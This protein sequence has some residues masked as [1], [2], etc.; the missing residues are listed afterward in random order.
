M[1]RRRY[2]RRRLRHKV[3]RFR[4]QRRRTSRRS[5]FFR[6]RRPRLFKARNIFPES[7]VVRIPFEGHFQINSGTA[8]N[9]ITGGWFVANTLS[10]SPAPNGPPAIQTGTASLSSAFQGATI[11]MG[12]TSTATDSWQNFTSMKSPALAHLGNI[13][14]R[15]RVLGWDVKMQFFPHVTTP[16]QI[17][18]QSMSTDDSD[19]TNKPDLVTNMHPIAFKLQNHSKQRSQLTATN[20]QATAK[21]RVPTFFY[22][23]KAWRLM[24]DYK[25]YASD[26]T[27]TAACT[28]GSMGAQPTYANPVNLLYVYV[29]LASPSTQVNL[30]A[31]S[32][33][34]GDL[35]LTWSPLV[36]FFEPHQNLDFINPL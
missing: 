5:R 32:S 9:F 18:V 16:T 34:Y 3:R 2:S 30:G 13:Y 21:G 15:Y 26:V 22:S 33:A 23:C 24:R 29:G 14:Q 20:A 27:W 25:Q 4:S 8:P 7:V 10:L 1:P 35:Y 36:K 19:L 17:F 11:G 6:S 12:R 31:P 28:P